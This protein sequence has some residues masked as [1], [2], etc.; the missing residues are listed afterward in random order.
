MEKPD[1]FE[2]LIDVPDNEKAKLGIGD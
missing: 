2:K 1:N